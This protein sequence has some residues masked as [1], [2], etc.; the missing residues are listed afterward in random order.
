MELGSDTSTG[1]MLVA[2]TSSP[3]DA[4]IGFGGNVV[5]E[6]VKAGAA[7]FV[8]SFQELIDQLAPL[9]NGEATANGHAL[10]P[11]LPTVCNG[12]KL[13]TMDG[14]ADE[15]VCSRPLTNGLTKDHSTFP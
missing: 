11:G 8:Y 2:Y 10:W 3:Q 12:V 15:Q 4:F 5:R 1:H 13:Q 6:K 7:W 14:F 9:E